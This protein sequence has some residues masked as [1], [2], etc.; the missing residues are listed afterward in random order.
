[1]PEI[2]MTI[3]GPRYPSPA[4]KSQ[5]ACWGPGSPCSGTSPGVYGVNMGE[6]H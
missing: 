6:M 5:A 2:P 3:P 4:W 1:M